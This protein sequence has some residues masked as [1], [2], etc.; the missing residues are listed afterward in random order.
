[1]EKFKKYCLKFLIARKVGFKQMRG[2]MVKKLISRGAKLVINKLVKLLI[3]VLISNV[4]ISKI[5][6]FRTN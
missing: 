3:L 4:Q 1:M 2:A 5:T 6:I